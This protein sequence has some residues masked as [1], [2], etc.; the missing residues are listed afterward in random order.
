M[1]GGGAAF[2]RASGIALAFCRHPLV[3]IIPSTPSIA[4]AATAVRASGNVIISDCPAPSG[5]TRHQTIAPAR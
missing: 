1:I 4:G 2:R 3:L 5:S